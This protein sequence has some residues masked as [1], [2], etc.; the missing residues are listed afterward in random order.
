VLAFVGIIAS[1]FFSVDEN[2]T[3]QQGDVF[4]I[5][6]YQLRYDELRQRKDPEKDVVFAQVSLLDGG[7]EYASVYPQKDFHHKSEQ[8][9]TEVAIRS[10]PYEDLYVVLSG[11]DEDG[12]ASFHV[13]VNPLVQ[14]IWIGIGVMVLGGI[15]VI[16]PDKQPKAIVARRQAQPRGKGPTAGRKLAGAATSAAGQP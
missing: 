10:L 6:G 1:S 5:G 14:L 2:F 12:S 11:W 16:F 4:E 3:V 13:F 15:F 9:A 7:Q 8:P